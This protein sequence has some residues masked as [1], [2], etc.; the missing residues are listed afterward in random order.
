MKTN[1]AC[2]MFVHSMDIIFLV[3][4]FKHLFTSIIT[5]TLAYALKRD[6]V[7]IIEP[8]STNLESNQ[9]LL[10]YQQEVDG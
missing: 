5:R 3:P 6:D 10:M 9:G 2:L 8:K 1:I 7:H 4:N